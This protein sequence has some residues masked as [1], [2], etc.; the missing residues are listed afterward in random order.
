MFVFMFL[1]ACMG[2]VAIVYILREL[3]RQR[4]G[5]RVPGSDTAIALEDLRGRVRNGRV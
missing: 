4:K 1:V 2:T 5:M 3:R